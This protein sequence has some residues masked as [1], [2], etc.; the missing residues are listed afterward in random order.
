MSTIHFFIGAFSIEVLSDEISSKF[1][2]RRA[3]TSMHFT[4]E[5]A[6]IRLGIGSEKC[7]D[8]IL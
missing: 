1:T 7:A 2:F 6:R 5:L 3:R 8:N 4:N